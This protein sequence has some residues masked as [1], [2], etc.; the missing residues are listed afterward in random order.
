MLELSSIYR[1]SQKPQILRRCQVLGFALSAARA[2]LGRKFPILA[3]TIANMHPTLS[4]KTARD[5]AIYISFDT[6][7]S[8]LHRKLKRI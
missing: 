8:K 3:A 6:T 7:L 4:T 1:I 5:V 2:A